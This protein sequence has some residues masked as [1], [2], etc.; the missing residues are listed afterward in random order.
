[1]SKVFSLPINP[2]FDPEFIETTFVSFL[3]KNEHL[4]FDLYFTCRMPPFVQDAM[5]DVFVSENDAN[6]VIE[7]ALW[8]S[9]ETGIPLSATFN[10]PYV[11]PDEN[12]LN[13]WIKN[14]RQVY[15]RGVRTVTLPHTSWVMTGK[16]QKEYP[17]LFIKNTILR[18]V[19]RPNEIVSLA[20]AGFHYVNLD[21][22]LMRD[23]DQLLAIKEAKEYC[24]SIGKPVKISMLANE[25]CWGGCPIMPEHYHYNNTRSSNK[26]QYFNSTISRISCSTWDALDGASSLKAANLPPW[27]SDWEEFLDLGIDVFKMHGRESMMR[28]KESM[29]IIT[30]WSLDEELLFP[31]FNEYIDD[32]DLEERPI[33]IWRDKIKTCKFDCWK[34]QYCDSV[35][36]SRLKRRGIE[37]NPKIKHIIESIDK[38]ERKDSSFT[39]TKIDGLSSDTVRH[40]LNNLCALSDT[41]YL[42][43]GCYAGSTFYPALEGNQAT[44]YAVDNFKQNLSPFRD[45]IVFFGYENP[46]EEF[47]KYF[48]EDTHLI[49]D[50]VKKVTIP[51]NCNV[52]FYDSDNNPKE[53]FISLSNIY[54]Y[55]EDEFILVVDDANFMGVV[56]TT[57]DF[58]QSK[59]LKVLFERKILT[60][61]PEDFDSW[62]NGVYIL[63]LKK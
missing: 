50:D 55:C 17:E 24:A 18:E 61:V 9:E 11:I 37:Y 43:L 8:L 60:E 29:D 28:L 54:K 42:E 13:V 19:T 15:D 23:R 25:G 34:C 49:E 22:D 16:I 53:Q 44:G 20:K 5:G 32:I 38:A 33:D 40:F 46:K 26:P 27:K 47:S 35:Y 48:T 39:K 14:F 52:I 31:E 36:G 6:N 7:M 58:I 51:E 1:M 21:R 62:W 59:N 4:I 41:K 12:N 2:K 10:N 3:K 63:L 56:E 57:K 45:D 30:R